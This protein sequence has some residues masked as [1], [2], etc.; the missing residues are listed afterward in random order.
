MT[1]RTKNAKYLI[2]MVMYW[3]YCANSF[4][5][6]ESLN[7]QYKGGKNG[8]KYRLVDIDR[9]MNNCESQSN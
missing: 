7:N 4:L 8:Y 6:I 3:T 2:F 1:E 9:I 5:R